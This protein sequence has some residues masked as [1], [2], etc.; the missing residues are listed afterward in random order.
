MT[1]WVTS[2][3]SLVSPAV[4]GLIL[5]GDAALATVLVIENDQELRR[6]IAQALADAGFRIVTASDSAAGVRAMYETCPDMV[7][8]DE[9]LPLVRG[10]QLCS[11][12]NRTSAIPII[13]LVN[14]EQGAASARFLAVGADTCLAKPLDPEMLVARVNS[15]FRR[16]GMKPEYSPPLGIELDTGQHQVHLGDRT[17]ELTPT[18]FRLL[19]CLALNSH[20]VVPYSELAVGVWGKDEI[21][22]S[23]LKFYIS[24]LRK[25]LA[26][27]SNSDFNLLNQRGVGFRFVKE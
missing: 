11:Y 22:P 23:D 18:E 20:R 21:S 1:V 16:C 3:Y 12:I 8:I 24:R 13:A 26:T 14:S 5:L 15:L 6:S 27:G 17:I 10:E 19:N 9:K 4:G 7:L 2:L 25:K